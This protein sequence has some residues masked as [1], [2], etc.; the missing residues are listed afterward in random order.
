[1]TKATNLNQQNM[2]AKTYLFVVI[3]LLSISLVRAQSIAAFIVDDQKSRIQDTWGSG[4]FE[5]S[6]DGGKRKHQGLDIIVKP[7]AKVYAPF[8]GT[9]VREAVPYKNDNSY[10]GIVFRGTGEWAAYEV[11]IFYAEGLFSG[12]AKKGQHI[13]YTQDLTLKY[14]TITNHIHVEVK[15]GND[16][17]D[18]FNMWQMSF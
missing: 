10:R 17:I 3:L 5:A 11:K 13:G 14:P 7:G 2:K 18:P 4:L 8:D 12:N 16:R 15:S 9:I 1:L 6:R